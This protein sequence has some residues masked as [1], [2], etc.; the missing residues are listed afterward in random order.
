MKKSKLFVI[1]PFL[2]T[3][4]L[5][6]CGGDEGSGDSGSG[7]GGPNVTYNEF[8]FN[9]ED[10]S[11]SVATATRLSAYLDTGLTLV[12]RP[13]D[14]PEILNRTSPF[15]FEVPTD[16]SVLFYMQYELVEGKEYA[17][18]AKLQFDELKLH[19]IA[20]E[21][22]EILEDDFY[23]DLKTAQ[24]D[25]TS[26][27]RIYKRYLSVALSKGTYFGY[28]TI[29]NENGDITLQNGFHVNVQCAYSSH[30]YGE[31]KQCE[32]CHYI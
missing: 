16:L 12:E 20:N 21:E 31:C 18:T 24:Y 11:L 15:R 13:E 3:I 8:G 22:E 14:N 26:S 17:D 1:L 23:L 32:Y 19:R 7:G 28:A 29:D 2:A 30:K 5:S 9:E 27:T 10:P 25:Y 6:A 4:A